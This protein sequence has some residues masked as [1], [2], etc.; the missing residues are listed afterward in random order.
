[1]IL[2]KNTSLVMIDVIS[3]DYNKFE[4]L[5][6][7]KDEIETTTQHLSNSTIFRA[8]GRWCGLKE[9]EVGKV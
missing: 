4:T 3:L 5:D 2:M 9:A 8:N 7:I 6:C 1:M